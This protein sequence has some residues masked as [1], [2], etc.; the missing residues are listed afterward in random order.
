MVSNKQMIFKLNKKVRLGPS[1]FLRT[2]YLDIGE[3]MSTNI[4]KVKE[5]VSLGTWDSDS[6]MTLLLTQF[7]LTQPT[8]I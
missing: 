5:L 6:M 1:H 8:R 2:E 4:L 3:K 7:R